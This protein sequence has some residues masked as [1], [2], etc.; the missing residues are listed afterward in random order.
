[1]DPLSEVRLRDIYPALADKVRKMAEIL[2]GD[3]IEIRVTQALRTWGE[4]QALYEQGRSREGKIVT[5]C[6][7]GHSYHNFGLAV[8]CCPSLYLP[9]QPFAPDWNA[10]HPTWKRMEAV[11][12]S[13]GLD[14]GATWRTFK[15]APHFQ[16]TGRFPEGSPTDE[17]RDM[18]HV[19]GMQAVWDAVGKSLS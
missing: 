16:L 1:M 5:N 15:D 2:A 6:Q 9:G 3:S 11:G 4:Q 8:D 14:S 7:A 18:F 13:L 19:A 12:Q 17:I 10:D